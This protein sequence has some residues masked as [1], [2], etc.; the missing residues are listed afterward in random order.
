MENGNGNEDE[1]E[2]ENRDE[3]EGGDG[4]GD[5]DGDRNDLDQGSALLAALSLW[6]DDPCQDTA[7]GTRVLVGA[8]RAAN[9]AALASPAPQILTGMHTRP[10][11]HGKY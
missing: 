4:E 8:L 2:N 9:A 11:R 5:G 1:M 10:P 6:W 3:D 7:P